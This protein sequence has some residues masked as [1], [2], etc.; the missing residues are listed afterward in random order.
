ML[1][2]KTR[3]LGKRLSERVARL[4]HARMHF[5][6]LLLSPDSEF[7]AMLITCSRTDAVNLSRPDYSP[8]CHLLSGSSHPPQVAGRCV[9]EPTQIAD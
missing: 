5:R 7:D 2:G 1:T 8:A 4:G 3:Q 6:T 9:G